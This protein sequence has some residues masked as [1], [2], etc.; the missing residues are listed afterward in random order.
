MGRGRS[1]LSRQIDYERSLRSS[2]T[3]L[4]NVYYLRG[5]AAQARV[6]FPDA[7][8]RHLGLLRDSIDAVNIE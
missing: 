6:H 3:N 4:G 5:D 8:P 7:L 1:P 2:L